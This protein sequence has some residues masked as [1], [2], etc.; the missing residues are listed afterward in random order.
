MVLREFEPG[1]I[2]KFVQNS[3]I[4]LNRPFK[5]STNVYI[6]FRNKSM[7]RTKPTIQTFSQEKKNR[8]K[9]LFINQAFPSPCSCTLLQVICGSFAYAGPHSQAGMGTMAW[10]LALGW[11][12]NVLGHLH[13]QGMGSQERSYRHS[14]K[15]PVSQ[16]LCQLS[17]AVSCQQ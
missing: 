7:H 8:L 13:A 5:L 3:S 2:L 14:Y 15:S 17:C 6:V 12:A 10:V 4:D 16:Q 1:W 11:S 9:F